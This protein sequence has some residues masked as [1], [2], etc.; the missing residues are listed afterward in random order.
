MSTF[1]AN[2]VCLH[3]K[4]GADAARSRVEVDTA[5]SNQRRGPAGRV[6]LMDPAEISP[7]TWDTRCSPI[8]QEGEP[9]GQVASRAFVTQE[10]PLDFSRVRAPGGAIGKLR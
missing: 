7:G 5:P 10:L 2:K 4:C 1:A 6:E 8:R 3:S 9:S